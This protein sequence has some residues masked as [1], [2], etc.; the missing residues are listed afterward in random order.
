VDF[1][2][3]EP[4][5]CVEHLSLGFPTRTPLKMRDVIVIRGGNNHHRVRSVLG[6]E[7]RVESHFSGSFIMFP[8]APKEMKTIHACY[9][10][11]L[12]PNAKEVCDGCR[13]R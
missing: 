13:D 10:F 12:Q 4:V 2:L 8:H 11:I 3:Q 9:L 6:V 7:R 1:T 5:F